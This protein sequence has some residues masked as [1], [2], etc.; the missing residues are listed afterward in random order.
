MEPINDPLW[1]IAKHRAKFKKSLISYC[2]IIPFLWCIWYFTQG[3]HHG[4]Y[5]RFDEAPHWHFHIPWPA[6][7]TLFWGF[8][9]ST[10]FVKAYVF[11]TQKSIEN[12]YQ[13]LKNKQQ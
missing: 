3:N 9:L 11:N 6:W 13:K 10:K 5:F 2:I 7:V 4:T 12:E 8:C 1:E